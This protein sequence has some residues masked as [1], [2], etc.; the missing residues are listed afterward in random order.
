MLA[1]YEGGLLVNDIAASSTIASRGNLFARSMVCVGLRLI[2]LSLSTRSRGFCAAGSTAVSF[3]MAP[4]RSSMGLSCSGSDCSV[5]FATTR[6][7]SPSDI[8]NVIF[9]LSPLICFFCGTNP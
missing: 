4:F 8:F 3:E 2:S 9:S 1:L 5:E 6:K 7:F